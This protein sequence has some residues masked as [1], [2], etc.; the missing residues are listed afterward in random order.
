LEDLNEIWNKI[1]K[2]IIQPAGKVRGKEE[3][4]KRNSVMKNSK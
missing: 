4:L 3:R 1:K 2:G